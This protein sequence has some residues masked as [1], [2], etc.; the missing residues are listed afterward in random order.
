MPWCHLVGRV[1][2]QDVDA[3]ELVDRT[4]DQLL[5]VGLLAQSPG[6]VTAVRPASSTQLRGLLRVVLLLGQVGDHDVGALP[7]EGQRGGPPDAG[8]PAGDEARLPSSLPLPR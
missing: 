1:A 5:A 4:L 8:V 2:D 7:G 3:A 6:A